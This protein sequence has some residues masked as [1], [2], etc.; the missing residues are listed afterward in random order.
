[1]ARDLEKVKQELRNKHEDAGGDGSDHQKL[2][3]LILAELNQKGVGFTEV[4]QLYQTS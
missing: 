1:M 3:Q 2:L 4:P